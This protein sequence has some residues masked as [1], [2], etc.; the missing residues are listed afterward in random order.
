MS[1]VL[2]ELLMDSQIALVAFIL[3]LY[4]GIYVLASQGQR[5]KKR[6]L[7]SFSRALKMALAQKEQVESEDHLD[8]VLSKV[9]SF[10]DQSNLDRNFGSSVE[11]LKHL[12]YLMHE[13]HDGRNTVVKGWTEHEWQIFDELLRRLRSKMP[14]A[15]LQGDAQRLLG[16]VQGHLEDRPGGLNALMELA[17]YIKSVEG[18]LR[19]QKRVN[20]L[21]LFLTVVSVILAGIAIFT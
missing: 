6:R 3:P 9:E 11:A 7:R 18:A 17:D 5:D 16:A 1:D 13:N 4:V 21:V 15:A 14:F 19:F 8:A 20:I 2:R 10:F 12:Q